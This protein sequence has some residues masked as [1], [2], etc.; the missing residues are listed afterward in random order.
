MTVI[1]MPGDAAQKVQRLRQAGYCASLVPVAT[2]PLGLACRACDT[3][4]RHHAD[5]LVCVVFST[6]EFTEPVY[7][8]D[9]RSTPCCWAGLAVY[10]EEVEHE[11]CFNGVTIEVPE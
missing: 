1:D 7:R 5:V 8:L 9:G 11:E 3:Y 4:D 2:W 10:L 6:T